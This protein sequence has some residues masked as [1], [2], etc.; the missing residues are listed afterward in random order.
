MIAKNCENVNCRR[1]E[2]VFECVCVCM[3]MRKKERERESM[4]K[5]KKYQ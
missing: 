4:S 1:R 5:T 3:C 2:N